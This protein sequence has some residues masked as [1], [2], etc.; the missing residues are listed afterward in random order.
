[1]E[2]LNKAYNLKIGTDILQDS[3][4]KLHEQTSEIISK[5]N[6]LQKDKTQKQSDQ[7]IYG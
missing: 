4:K 5:F 2:V 3:V 1:M 6:Q 7:S